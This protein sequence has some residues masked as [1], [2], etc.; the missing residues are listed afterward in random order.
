MSRRGR[1]AGAGGRRVGVVRGAPFTMVLALATAV[2]A[3]TASDEEEGDSVEDALAGMNE[4]NFWERL[5]GTIAS[6][7]EA[8]EGPGAWTT[9]DRN[10]RWSRGFVPQRV[11]EENILPGEDEDIRKMA[12]DIQ[13][14]QRKL[15]ASNRGVFERAFHAKPHACVKGKL[16]VHVPEDVVSRA[17]L[18]A[19]T[20]RASLAVGL[21]APAD[22]PYDVWVRWSNG[23]G[24]RERPDGE[25]DVRGL[26]FKVLGVRGARLPDGPTFF[27]QEAGTQDFLLTNGSTTPA[28]TSEAFAA[29]GTAQA[30]LAAAEGLLEKGGALKDFFKYLVRNPRVGSTLVHRVFAETK[31]HDSVLSQRF[32]SGGAFALGVDASGR[33]LQ[34][35]K[36]QAQTGT[37]RDDGGGRGTCAFEV[38]QKQDPA[39]FAF[40]GGQPRG[41]GD[42]P[43]DPS[44]LSTGKRG[45]KT[46]LVETSLCIELS[47]QFQ[48]HD[49]A[50]LH[51]QRQPIEDTSVEW[52]EAD[53]PFVPVATV[54]V[55]RRQ[56]PSAEEDECNALSWNPWHGLVEH[57]PLGNIM[58]VRQEV[59]AAS[60]RLRNAR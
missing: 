12:E 57:R 49:P 52:R 13:A 45:V 25:V 21:F 56:D 58:R 10:N 8:V 43:G 3:C 39:D 19:T 22:V 2:A 47:L 9:P 42:R 11:G 14:I 23:V 48:R 30:N 29:F 28:P 17:R 38:A 60:A 18:P 31:A 35:V 32:F 51:E 26:A 33:P 40:P 7:S 36:M 34:A 24:G 59:L 41:R 54:V 27:R 5:T 6:I 53:S 44:Y 15:L 4:E 16:F 55:E 50:M 46:R 20:D 1:F 37:W